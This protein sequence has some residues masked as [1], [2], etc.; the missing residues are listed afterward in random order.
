MERFPDA[1]GDPR[2]GS[3][4]S[5]WPGA[6]LRCGAVRARQ[7]APRQPAAP[8]PIV[9]PDDRGPRVTWNAQPARLERRA[10][11]R[12]AISSADKE[13]ISE[14]RTPSS[15]LAGPAREW[16]RT[17]DTCGGYSGYSEDTA[18]DNVSSPKPR[19][20]RGYSEDTQKWAGDNQRLLVRAARTNPLHGATRVGGIGSCIGTAESRGAVIELEQGRISR[21]WQPDATTSRWRPR[22]NHGLRMFRLVQHEWEE[23]RMHLR[24]SGP[25]A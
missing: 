6:S 2:A 9:C 25:G 1:G 17:C 19:T 14:L 21:S 13:L 18:A 12:P 4:E 8:L 20:C 3:I 22:P 24:T 23:T 10:V 11:P 5:R 16:T 7:P 15:D